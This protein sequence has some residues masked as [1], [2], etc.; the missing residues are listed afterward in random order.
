MYPSIGLE[1]TLILEKKAPEYAYLS[2]RGPRIE[3]QEDG[4]VE[5]FENRAD[6]TFYEATASQYIYDYLYQYSDL[7]VI[8]TISSKSITASMNRL[9]PSYKASKVRVHNTVSIY[10][11]G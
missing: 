4:K 3:N 11:V 10:P 5:I 9:K 1:N 8:W 7:V 6:T 2:L